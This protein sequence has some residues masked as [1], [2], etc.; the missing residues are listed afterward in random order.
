MAAA[1]S[2][3]FTAGKGV[4][5]TCGS[6][7]TDGS[8]IYLYGGSRSG[9]MM[10]KLRTWDEENELWKTLA[11]GP[12]GVADC[13]CTWLSNAVVVIGGRL[14]GTKVHET[15]KLCSSTFAWRK[16]TDKASTF[17]NYQ[18]PQKYQCFG[19]TATAISDRSC[20]VFGGQ[21]SKH[22]FKVGLYLFQIPPFPILKN[23]QPTIT[24]LMV[25]SGSPPTA[26][27]G[28]S[29]LYN[30]DMNTFV[31]AGGMSHGGKLLNDIHL[32][33]Y[34]TMTW[35]EVHVPCRVHHVSLIPL[36]DN[37][38]L[39]LGSNRSL[40]LDTV[41]QLCSQVANRF[42]KKPSESVAK[43]NVVL[44]DEYIY[45]LGSSESWAV[46]IS[47]IPEKVSFDV[48]G[49][50]SDVWLLIFDYLNSRE[51]ITASQ[52]CAS[53]RCLAV[54]DTVWTP[55]LSKF[56][57]KALRYATAPSAI[58][59][60]CKLESSLR[61]IRR[62]SKS[63]RSDTSRVAK[64]FLTKVNVN[65][66]CCKKLFSLPN[67]II[68]EETTQSVLVTGDCGKIEGLPEV[69]K[70]ATCSATNE[71]A[72]VTRDREFFVYD[73]VTG[74][75]SSRIPIPRVIPGIFDFNK[76]F[77][78]IEAPKLQLYS[79]KNKRNPLIHEF[80]LGQ[81]TPIAH[82]WDQGGDF[83]D[84]NYINVLLDNNELVRFDLLSMKKTS[85]NVPPLSHSDTISRLLHLS[86]NEHVVT[87]LKN[88]YLMDYRVSGIVAPIKLK[89]QAYSMARVSD[90]AV[91]L[92]TNNGIMLFDVRK[93]AL[94]APPVFPETDYMVCS[95]SI[96]NEGTCFMTY[97]YE[98]QVAVWTWPELK[99]FVVPLP[100]PPILVST[101][102]TSTAILTA[103]NIFKLD[104]SDCG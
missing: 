73:A 50:L 81:E 39:C 7:C 63:C 30:R 5:T 74:K 72:I 61:T 65:S 96:T 86:H 91:L 28:H 23:T 93:P 33:H 31:V 48:A 92:G 56:T 58:Q 51:L 49:I 66:S 40:Y 20:I 103:N 99:Y 59:T 22:K 70:L 15:V 16:E 43:D 37:N 17:N 95:S 29:A 9:K 12:N 45:Q 80:D 94:V 44:C 89:S 87:T 71:F 35:R 41:T 75:K 60:Y 6:C 55:K 101:S 36:H 53:L 69:L 104:F 76:D 90:D 11:E 4:E 3:W 32:L 62:L 64:Q 52:S 100:G 19:H 47:D 21:T 24:P 8:S 14:N 85:V 98:P 78:L 2:G 42:C 10:N 46:D 88:L 34:T 83:S 97:G 13:S 68:G 79:R 26:R 82:T 102:P 77:L 84:Q 54:S 18:L 1:A 57:D 27:S 25:S 38:I 67:R